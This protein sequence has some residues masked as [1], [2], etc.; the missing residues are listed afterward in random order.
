MTY[1]CP[2]CWREVGAA[3]VKCP[4]CHSDLAALDHRAFVDKLLAALRHPE[5]TTRQRAAFVLGELH[6]TA[7]VAAFDAL[8]FATPEPFFACEMVMALGKIDSPEA[9]QLLIRRG[10]SAAALALEH[11]ACDRSPSVRRLARE[12]Q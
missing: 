6:A 1:F 12:M 8:V 2:A 10:G 11:A 9:Q 3:A 7:A 5:P 4:R